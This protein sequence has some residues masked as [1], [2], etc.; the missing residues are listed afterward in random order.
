MKYLYLIIARILPCRHKWVI[1]KET[2]ILDVDVS[3]TIP[4]STRFT[5]QCKKCGDVKFVKTK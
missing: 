2:D 5:L 3:M 1:I 4:V